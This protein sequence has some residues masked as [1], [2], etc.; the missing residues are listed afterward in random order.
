M[1]G[2]SESQL[3]VIDVVVEDFL[4]NTHPLEVRVR[5]TMWAMP[6]VRRVPTRRFAK[7]CICSLATCM[8][9]IPTE[10]IVDRQPMDVDGEETRGSTPKLDV[11]SPRHMSL[12]DHSRTPAEV[13][14]GA[15]EL[16]VAYPTTRGVTWA[17][18]YPYGRGGGTPPWGAHCTA[19]DPSSVSSGHP[20]SITD[21]S[22]RAIPGNAAPTAPNASIHASISCPRA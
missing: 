4:R 3:A 1:E 16:F 17:D 13:L 8:S 18:A 12:V 11:P 20:R 15:E 9:A 22:N 7:R 10:T 2:A 5:A 21:W 6:P 14:A 19:P